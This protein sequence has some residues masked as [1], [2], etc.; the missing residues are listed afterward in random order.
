MKIVCSKKILVNKIGIAQKAVCSKTNLEALKNFVLEASDNQLIITGY[1]LDLGILATME[2]D[3][4]VSGKFAV[5]AKLFGDIIRKL[6]LDIL[7]LEFNKDNNTILITSGMSTFQIVAGNLD[8][9]PTL[10]SI[11]NGSKFK[12]NSKEFKSMVNK[13]KIAISQDNTKPLL[14]G[15][16]MEIDTNSI[17]MVALDGYRLAISKHEVESGIDSLKKVI[18]PGRTLND[19]SS[20]LGSDNIDIEF[21]IDEKY[22]SVEFDDVKIISRLL[23]G[24]YI[25]YTRLLPNEYKTEI[26]INRLKF[27]NAIDR[28]TILAVHEKNSLV[29]FSIADEFIQATCNSDLGNLSEQVEINKTGDSL[30][31]AFNS[32][33]L[34]E[35]LKIMSSDD[36]TLKF[37]TNLNP[38]TIHPMDESDYTYL[39]LPIRLAN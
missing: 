16:L 23:E 35:A 10:P 18:V 6:P 11:S 37:T 7:A 9:F 5:N 34:T 1:D 20:A 8:E 14:T 26:K 24:E 33:Y 39:L 25:E 28:A 32:R 4:E 17:N 22:I 3:V 38:C 36:V 13:T 27:L 31:I 21:T 19:I 2:A 15:A 30:N 12:L 29:K